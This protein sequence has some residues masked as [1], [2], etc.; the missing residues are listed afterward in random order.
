[1]VDGEMMMRITHLR[2]GI[3]NEWMRVGFG[4]HYCGAYRVVISGQIE[5]YNR[6]CIRMGRAISFPNTMQF[7]IDRVIARAIAE[8]EMQNAKPEK[9]AR[10]DWRLLKAM[11]AGGANKEQIAHAIAQMRKK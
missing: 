1:M 4:C 6:D 9:P 10:L 7:V 8:W 5:Y 3:C 11:R 2:C